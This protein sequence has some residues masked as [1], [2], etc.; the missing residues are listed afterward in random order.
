MCLVRSL[1]CEKAL[2]HVE[3]LQFLIF[4]ASPALFLLGKSFSG[5]L[6]AGD[7]CRRRLLPSGMEELWLVSLKS[8]LALDVVQTSQ[9]LHPH[10]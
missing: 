6:S 1:D 9:N 8:P 4:A 3:H 10:F 5:T 2:P 7:P